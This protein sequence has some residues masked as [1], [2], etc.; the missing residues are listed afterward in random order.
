MFAKIYRPVPSAMQSGRAGSK[1][2]VI[3]F[4][5][6]SRRGVEPL[7]GWISSSDTS[8]QVRIHFETRDEAIAFA[9][10][11]G[12]AFQVTERREP[13]RVVKSYSDNFS[14]S[15]RRPWTH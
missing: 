12:L 2:W 6:A 11:E 7:M 5:N 13:R 1:E 15:R 14:A 3:E 9:Q 8:S 10:R 4:D